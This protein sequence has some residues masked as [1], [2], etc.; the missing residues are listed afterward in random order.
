M[1]LV[2]GAV[3]AADTAPVPACVRA[4][5]EA[6]RCGPP[7][8]SSMCEPVFGRTSLLERRFAGVAAFCPTHSPLDN[9]PASSPHKPPPWLSLKIV[10]EKKV[11]GRALPRPCALHHL[12]NH[13]AIRLL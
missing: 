13:A 7:E 5:V 6:T 2:A 11:R 1:R 4:G 3:R 9:P 10:A 8:G 12:R